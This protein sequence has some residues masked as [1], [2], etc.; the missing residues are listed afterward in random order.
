MNN[1]HESKTDYLIRKDIKRTKTRSIKRKMP[2][3]MSSI[4]NTLLF[5]Y[6]HGGIK[7]DTV[8]EMRLTMRERKGLF[9][10]ITSDVPRC[11]STLCRGTHA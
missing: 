11:H 7:S 4:Y 9:A 1:I 3:E 8:A 6:N 10:L 5:E 2:R